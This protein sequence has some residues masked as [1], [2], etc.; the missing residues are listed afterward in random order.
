MPSSWKRLVVLNNGV[1]NGDACVGAYALKKLQCVVV[2]Y[3]ADNG[4]RAEV[5]DSAKHVWENLIRTS[6]NNHVC[7]AFNG[8]IEHPSSV[9]DNFRRE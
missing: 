1:V 8:L 6:S 5:K 2:E 4:V 3:G 7:S 9:H